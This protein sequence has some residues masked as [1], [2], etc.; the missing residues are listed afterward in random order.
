MPAPSLIPFD[1]STYPDIA[2]LIRE[3]GAPDI[4]EQRLDDVTAYARVLI[5]RESD[6]LEVYVTE[7]SGHPQN[8]GVS[9]LHEPGHVEVVGIAFGATRA[10]DS[11]SRH[12]RGDLEGLGALLLLDDEEWEAARHRITTVLHVDF[13]PTRVAELA[14]FDAAVHWTERHR[15]LAINYPDRLG[16]SYVDSDG[17]LRR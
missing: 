5:L 15:F 4:G 2:R 3:A 10:C 6:L 14:S 13:P 1:Q 9:L 17:A 11:P 7:L 16:K 8:A 12:I